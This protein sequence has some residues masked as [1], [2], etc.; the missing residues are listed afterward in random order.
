MNT[1]REDL[2][3]IVLSVLCL[4]LLF[5]GSLWI[6]LPFLAATVWATTLVLTTW[7][8]LK[9]LEARFGGRRAPAVV[10]MTLALLL[11]L[12]IPLWLA[13]STIADHTD[14]AAAF[15]RKL[16]ED[17]LPAP[18]D[19]VGGVPLVGERLHAK[20]SEWANAGPAGIKARLGPY[21]GD[22][23]RWTVGRAGS[24]GATLVQF[25]FVVILSAVMYSGGETAAIGVRRFFRR[26]AGDRGDESVVLAA[27]AIRSVALGV[28]V[29]AL[30]QTVLGT[31]GLAAAGVPFAGLL[32]AV[33]LMLCI[34]QLGPALVMFPAVAWMYWTGDNVWAT[35]LLVW[36]LVVVSLDNI[37]RPILIRKGAD[38]PILLIIAGVI[39]GMLSFGLIGIFVGPVVLAVAYRLL[40]SWIDDEPGLASRESKPPA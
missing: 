23:A 13:I 25:L 8:V 19:W 17:G 32:G 40:G 27:N 1:K 28:G 11:L 34:A 15:A 20:L 35:V 10:V 14:E 9:F 24:L 6:L 16:A 30:V 18:P 4:L 29:T 7:P 31:I 5:A 22:A 37:L 38:L 12:V 26:L 2:A 39:G 21:L 33:T 3:Q 36:S